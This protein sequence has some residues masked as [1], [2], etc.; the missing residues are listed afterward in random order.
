M[1]QTSS[2]TE[3]SSLT[4]A[5]KALLEVQIRITSAAMLGLNHLQVLDLRQQQE[6]IQAQILTMT[7]R[8]RKSYRAIREQVDIA[9]SRIKSAA[10]QATEVSKGQANLAQ[11]VAPNLNSKK[12]LSVCVGDLWRWDSV[13][14]VWSVVTVGPTEVVL[15]FEEMDTATNGAN[16]RMRGAMTTLGI[17]QFKHG[18]DSGTCHLLSRRAY[19]FPTVIVEPKKE[20]FKRHPDCKQKHTYMVMCK[21]CEFWMMASQKPH[22]DLDAE[23]E[24]NRLK[25]N[26]VKGIPPLFTGRGSAVFGSWN[27]RVPR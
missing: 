4:A 25:R 21:E 23:D 15:S 26:T 16:L 14:E 5:K 13:G 19:A 10:Q 27:G 20:P 2:H 11:A 22:C 8:S 17:E 9:Q 7:S 12:P 24:I 3:F 18:Y 6:Q 1:P